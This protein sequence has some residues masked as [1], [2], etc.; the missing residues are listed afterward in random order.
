MPISGSGTSSIHSPGSAFFF[1]SASAPF[2][3]L[4]VRGE[5][6]HRIKDDDR[7]LVKGSR[8]SPEGETGGPDLGS[9]FDVHL[10]V[11][12]SKSEI[13]E[14]LV[15]EGEAGDAAH[16]SIAITKNYVARSDRPSA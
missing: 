6:L 12:S 9:R 14:A 16:G 8:A 7:F 3:S 13:V 10:A 4:F 15:D 11:D 5:P 2:L 1:T